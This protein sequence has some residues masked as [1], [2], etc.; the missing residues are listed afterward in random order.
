MESIKFIKNLCE[1]ES[2][3]DIFLYENKTILI[4]MN[5]NG[6]FGN[7]ATLFTGTGTL[8]LTNFLYSNKFIVYC[9]KSD[10]DCIDYFTEIKKIGIDIDIHIGPDEILTEKI[11]FS[12]RTIVPKNKIDLVDDLQEILNMPK[13]DLTI[14]NPP[15][16]FKE[17][18]N[19][20]MNIVNLITEHCNQN[21]IIMPNKLYYKFKSVKD[22]YN[23]NHLISQ[24]LKKVSEV[25]E[26][27]STTWEYISIYYIS[28]DTSP[29]LKVYFY[30]DDFKCNRDYDSRMEI[31]DNIKYGKPLVKLIKKFE[32]KYNELMNTYK[33]MV[34]DCSNFIY[35]ENKVGLYGITKSQQIKLQ[36]VKK[37]LKNGVYKYCLYKGSGNH[38]YDELQEYKGDTS[39]FN[40]Q[41]CW[42]TNSKTVY[43]NMKYWFNCPLFDL[44]RKFYFKGC[45]YAACWSYIN[46]PALDF[47]MKTKDFIDYVDSL[48]KFTKAEIKLLKEFNVHNSETLKAK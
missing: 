2:L 11:S 41:I 25:F 48:N 28:N 39:I 29:K 13:I 1:F 36:R 23:N 43:E 44:W 26:N 8:K 7:L 42:L 32:P 15:Y 18:N 40:G 38:Q 22:F 21:I 35:E 47:S 6:C 3:N 4:A 46:I 37:Y 12:K 20:D 19:L 17:D 16:S 5:M 24:E 34:H 33:S 9:L 10:T 14:M 27:I 31:W 30:G 45:K